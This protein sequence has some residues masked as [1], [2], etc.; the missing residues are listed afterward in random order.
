MARETTQYTDT[1]SIALRADSIDDYVAAHPDRRVIFAKASERPG[2]VPVKDTASWPDN[3]EISY[4]SVAD[5]SG[6][7]LVHTQAPSSESGDW[8]AAESHYFAPD[9][10]TILHQY[11]I[12]SFSSGCAAILRE[13]KRIFLSPTGAV[14][15][16]TRRFSDQN[17]RS[18][19]ADSCERRSDD[20]PTPRRSAQELPFLPTR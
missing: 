9:G 18:V 14:L 1:V 10:R 13:I 12:S 19:V 3:T 2:L 20:S 5:T 16:E 7:P 4:N 8:S 17:G 15:A 6:R 11:R